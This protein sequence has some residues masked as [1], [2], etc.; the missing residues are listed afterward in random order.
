MTPQWGVPFDI[1]VAGRPSYRFVARI[2][3]LDFWVQDGD[4]L[5]AWVPWVIRYGPTYDHRLCGD[6]GG[7]LDRWGRANRIPP[8]TIAKLK[9]LIQLMGCQK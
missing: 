3:Q 8:K 9:A 5:R 1:P 6:P 2:D 4:R 7:G